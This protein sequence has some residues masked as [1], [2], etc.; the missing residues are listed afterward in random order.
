MML[1]KKRRALSEDGHVPFGALEEETRYYHIRKTTTR[2]EG[3][4]SI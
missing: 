4:P 2:E 3:C 1:V